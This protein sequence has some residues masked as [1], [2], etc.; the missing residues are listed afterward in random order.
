MVM[1]ARSVDDIIGVKV[2]KLTPMEDLGL[3][4]RPSGRGNDRLIRCLCDCG[5]EYRARASS[6]RSQSVFSCG[7][8]RGVTIKH[9]CGGGAKKDP[10]RTYRIWVSMKQRVQNPKNTSYKKYGGRGIKLDPRWEDF[11]AFYEDMG[12]PPSEEH[13]LDR[14]DNDGDYTKANCRWATPAE[15]ARNRRSNVYLEYNGISKT[16]TDWAADLG[17]SPLT[18]RGRLNAG[19]PLDEALTLRKLPNNGRNS[20]RPSNQSTR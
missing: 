15:Q 8:T 12:D 2:G 11:A 7:C 3:H 6:L 5:Q 19:W 9:G 18:L 4:P 13:T 14:R 1:V 20:T 17:I 10:T 16:I